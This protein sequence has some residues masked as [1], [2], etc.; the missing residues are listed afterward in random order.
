MNASA[1]KVLLQEDEFVETLWADPV[2]TDLYR[3]DNS[4]FWRTAYRGG[5]SSKRT[6]S[7]TEC[8]G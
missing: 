7:Q 5:T 3:L 6:P 8:C 2:G 1:V 4:P